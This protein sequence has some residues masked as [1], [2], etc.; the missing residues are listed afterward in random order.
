MIASHAPPLMSGA[1]DAGRCGLPTAS[2][3]SAISQLQN[4]LAAADF[5]GAIQKVEP[6]R[7]Q[8]QASF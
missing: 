4:E 6:V 7:N 8:V 2:P 3:A 5:P 1:G